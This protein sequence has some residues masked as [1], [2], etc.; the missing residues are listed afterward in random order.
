M[1]DN[2][3]PAHE[4]QKPPKPKQKK[5][6]RGRPR[7]SKTKRDETVQRLGLRVDEYMRAYGISRTAVYG[8]IRRGEIE[9]TK[10]GKIRILFPLKQS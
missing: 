5:R 7:G 2:D 4:Q 8:G 3:T 1:S 10:V 6:G 9:T